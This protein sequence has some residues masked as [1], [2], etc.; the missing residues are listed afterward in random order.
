MAEILWQRNAGMRQPA[1]MGMLGMVYYCNHVSDRV[2]GIKLCKCC[3][4]AGALQFLRTKTA[5][6]GLL[7]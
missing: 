6:I 7:Y 1:V 2:Q 3:Q 5:T 4:G